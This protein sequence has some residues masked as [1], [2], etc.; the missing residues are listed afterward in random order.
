MKHISV[1]KQRGKFRKL[2]KT[3]DA[4]AILMSL[5]PGEASEDSPRNEHPRC[6]QWMYVLSGEGEVSVEASGKRRKTAIGPGSLVVI[7]KREPHQVAATGVTP[8]VSLNLYVPPAYGANG[9][10]LPSARRAAHKSS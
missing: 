2:A 9:E 3:A 10:S 6:E 5:Q 4:Q 1:D 8:L 7:E